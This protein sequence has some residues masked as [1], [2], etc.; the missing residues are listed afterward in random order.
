MATR[1]SST[2]D[3]LSDIETIRE[4]MSRYHP[5]TGPDRYARFSEEMLGIT[6]TWVLTKLSKA[7]DQHQQVV[8]MG[9][10]GV[11][12]SFDAA[13]LGAAALYCNPDT[14]VP[15]TA[16]NG[17]TVKNSIW[18][19]IKNIHRGSDLPG[20]TLDNSRELRTEFDAKWY[21]QCLS[22]RHPEDLEGDHNETLIYVIE[23]AEK[24][25]V[26]ADHIDSARS[27]L[28]SENDR[29][30]VLANP[31][32][33]EENVVSTLLAS[34]EWHNLIFP[35][36]T[37]HNVRIDRGIQAGEKIK[38]LSTV[39]KIKKDWKDYHDEPW[40]GLERAIE[41]STPYVDEDGNPT[42]YERERA[43]DNPEFRE[44]LHDRW[45][46]RRAG[47]V[48]PDGSSTWRPW[49]VADVEAAY[50]RRVNEEK[51][52][53]KPSHTG[54]DVARG[55]GDMTLHTG[56]HSQR[57]RVHYAESGTN[58]HEQ[59]LELQDQLQSWEPA[60]PEVNVDAVGEG[61]A[62]ADELDARVPNVHR[63]S[64]GAVAT[65][66]DN[67]RY[68]WAEGLQL[69]GEWLR[70]GGS[71]DNR[72]L[73]KELKVGAR[74]LEFS[75]RTLKSRGGKVIEATPKETLKEELDRSPDY[76][77]SLL[78]AI[79]ARDAEASDDGGWIL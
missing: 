62:L 64:N 30:L 13:A 4:V 11:G 50:N 63:F 12:K 53:E 71:F 70:N 25:G 40:P 67:Y 76:L 52:P 24:P 22:P 79:H 19:P 2:S 8:A 16:G 18:K 27:T 78:M 48:P 74:V 56:L 72:W 35:S 17:D 44:D 6:R 15:I 20:R 1:Q 38:G 34:D 5:S 68:C 69:I 21:L 73:Y 10:N 66:E 55:G 23:E 65:D 9:G 31:P 29:I 32:T 28:T 75:E 39:W 59:R 60:P 58:H 46:K 45:Y 37:S 77:D 3:G 43:D 42:V 7:L 36:W 57:A 51:I 26:T 54:I 33:D 47:I 61:S 49:S 14:T 41:I